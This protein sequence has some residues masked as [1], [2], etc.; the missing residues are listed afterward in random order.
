MSPNSKANDCAIAKN[1]FA[2]QRVPR[3]VVIAA[4][5]MSNVTITLQDPAG[6]SQSVKLTE[7]SRG[8][9]FMLEGWFK[10]CKENQISFGDTLVIEVV[11]KSVFQLHI[12][13]VGA[14]RML[15]S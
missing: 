14:A 8:R 5:L 6:R 4:G 12:F 15:K 7:V 9:L 13:K 10:C 11:K 1:V 2:V 3:S